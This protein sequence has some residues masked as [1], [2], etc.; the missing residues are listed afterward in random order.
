MLILTVYGEQVLCDRAVKG[1][2]YVIIYQNG[3]EIRRDEGISSF[4]GYVLTDEDG[5][6]AEFETQETNIPQL[7]DADFDELL[8]Q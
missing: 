4:D 8:R 1:L 6:P 2:N 3:A 7:T 5:S